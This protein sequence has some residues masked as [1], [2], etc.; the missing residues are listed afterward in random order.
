[1]KKVIF[2]LILIFWTGLFIYPFL[3]MLSATVRPEY[4]IGSFNIIPS[5]LSL[6]SYSQ[7]FAKIP[8]LR[9][10]LNSLFVAL[11]VTAGVLV[12]CSV[13]GYALSRLR[14]WG[15]NVI[16]GI[17][18]LTMM[19]P[20]QIIIIPLYI[21]MVKFGWVNSYL[22][23]IVPW[24]VSALGIVLFRQYFQ[25]IPQDVID[26]ARI[27]GCNELQIIF[28]IIWP[29]SVPTLITVGIL[30]FMTTWNEVLW[31]LIVIRERSL[32]TMPQLVTIFTVGGQA[33]SQLGVQLA[34]ATLLA[35]PIV[36]AYTFF[37]KYF[38]ESMATTGLK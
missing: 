30:T 1:M 32:M 19:I 10:F 3:W 33:E 11:T 22:S 26:A 31:P 9:A 27:D 34:A 5:E 17:V 29:I 2:Y 4:E 36:I 13:I 16:F 28:R 8:I 18:L 12:F 14:F 23:L 24:M 20:I 35:L 37:Q 15:R 6:Y 25:S 21:L 7:V 38:I